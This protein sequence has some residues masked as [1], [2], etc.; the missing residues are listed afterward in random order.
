MIKKVLAVMGIIVAVGLLAY[1]FYG[2]FY[3]KDCT[4]NASCFY[5]HMEKCAHAKYINAQNMT[6][7]YKILGK[8]G[9]FCVVN[10]KMLRSDLRKEDM[11]R[12]VSQSM[13]CSIPLGVVIVPESDLDRC[14]GVLKE[15]M[16]NRIIN[17]LY[18]YIVQ[19]I[20]KIEVQI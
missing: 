16:Q 5:A 14:H 7:E 18:A 3:Y 4:N 17:K 20:G 15:E 19:N 1:G 11:S 10:V 9:D 8:E 6:F 12:L 2:L 13:K